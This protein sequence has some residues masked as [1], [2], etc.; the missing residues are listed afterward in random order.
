V[1]CENTGA[2]HGPTSE[3]WIFT[4]DQWE[5]ERLSVISPMRPV[6]LEAKLAAEE[7]GGETS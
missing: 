3:G 2:G 1:H 4:E 5:A 6:L 7:K